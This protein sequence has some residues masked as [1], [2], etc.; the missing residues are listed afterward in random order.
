VIVLLLSHISHPK[1]L[2]ADVAVLQDTYDVEVEYPDDTT[3]PI[4]HQHTIDNDYNV[5]WEKHLGS[6][7]DGRVVLCRSLKTDK[8]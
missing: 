6:G 3:K 2:L 1:L 4:I 8:V 5:R 7:V